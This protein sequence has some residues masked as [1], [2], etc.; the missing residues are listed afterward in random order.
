MSQVV[1]YIHI[2]AAKKKVRP[3]AWLAPLVIDDSLK[4]RL[5]NQRFELSL[6]LGVQLSKAQFVRMLLERGLRTLEES[7]AHR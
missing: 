4:K 3:A 2:M 7:P 6:S 5:E 1:T